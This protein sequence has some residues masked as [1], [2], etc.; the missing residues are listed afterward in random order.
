M[1]AMPRSA[2]SRSIVRR[3]LEVERLRTLRDGAPALPSQMNDVPGVSLSVG[4]RR[5]R[6]VARARD[7]VALVEPLMRRLA[8]P[9]GRSPPMCH[10]PKSAVA[11]PT[12][13]S[14]SAIVTSHSVMPAP[15]VAPVRIA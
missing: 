4:D 2:A 12:D 11:Y 14:A 7:A 6:L 13:F 8:M 3:D 9:S 15:C 5:L 10:L 1:N